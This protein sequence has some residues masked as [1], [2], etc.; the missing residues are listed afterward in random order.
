MRTRRALTVVALLLAVAVACSEP[1]PK[2]TATPTT[3][4][5]GSGG[6]PHGAPV[7]T[8]APKGT[9]LAPLMPAHPTRARGTPIRIGTINQ[10]TGA[11]GAFPELTTADRTAIDFIN[12]ELGGVDGHPIELVA[13]N[14]Q[15][16]PDLSQAC[17]QQMVAQRRARGGR[18]HRHLGHRHHD[19]REQRHPVRRRHPGQLR[20]RAQQ[21]QL[22]VQRR[23]LGRGARRGR[24]RVAQA[25]RPPRRDHRRRL[26]SD[27]RRR[28]ARQARAGTTR[29]RGD[30]RQRRADQ[31]RHGAGART[32]RRSPT[33]TRSSRS[34]PTAAASRRCSPRS[35]SA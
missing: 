10:D 30:A 5:P 27:H 7:L 35:S 1:M 6:C 20:G 17:A 26:R 2:K 3:T 19:A 4:R 11:A 25:P 15:F 13:C 22:P 14:T 29:R 24:V 16:S 34:P 32:P 9:M 8:C 23:H 31:R 12:T 18:R 33:P 21:G 28:R